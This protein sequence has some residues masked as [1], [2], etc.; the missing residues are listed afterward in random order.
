MSQATF[1]AVDSNGKIWGIIAERQ[2]IQKPVSWYDRTTSY[3]EYLPGPW[4]LRT[5]EGYPVDSADINTLTIHTPLGSIK[6]KLRDLTG[7]VACRQP[8]SPE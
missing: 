6:A 4:E 5:E 1:Y 2:A 3:I 7:S 8:A